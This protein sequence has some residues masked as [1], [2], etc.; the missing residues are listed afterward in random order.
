MQPNAFYMVYI[1]TDKM[2]LTVLHV[3]F[4]ILIKAVF[5]SLTLCYR[6]SRG[7]WI[8]TGLTDSL[9]VFSC[10]KKQELGKIISVLS[11][12]VSGLQHKQFI[13]L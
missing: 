4:N 7:H 2:I 13:K 10:Q 8:K 6:M 11:V 12:S 1:C 9:V 3:L 5:G